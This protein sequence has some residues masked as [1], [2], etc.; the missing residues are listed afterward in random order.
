MLRSIVLAACIVLYS[1]SIAH[2]DFY[3]WVDKDGK[4]F[5][6][7]D[8]RQI[9]KK[10]REH[11]LKIKLDESR[12]SVGEKPGAPGKTSVRPATTKTKTTEARSSHEKAQNSTSV[13]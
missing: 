6:T 5:F 10:Y 3:R 11:A 12:V 1:V 9:P 4:E 13:N 8:R 7:N 2:A